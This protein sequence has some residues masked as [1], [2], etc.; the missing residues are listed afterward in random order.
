MMN[1]GLEKESD[2]L[3]VPVLAFIAVSVFSC[4]MRQSHYL[5]WQEK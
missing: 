3:A 4:F 2:F 5:N 1:K